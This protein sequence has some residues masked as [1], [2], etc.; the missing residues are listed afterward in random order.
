M[1]IKRETGVPTEPCDCGV[2][3]AADAEGLCPRCKK[4][5]ETASAVVPREKGS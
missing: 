2:E 4:P 1:N 3:M 5:V